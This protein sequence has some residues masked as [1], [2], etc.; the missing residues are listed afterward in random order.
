MKKIYSFVLMAAMLLVGT[1]A[2]AQQVVAKI[3]TQEYYSLQDAVNAVPAGG[4]ATIQLQKSITLDA[5]VVIPQVGTS[6]DDV[7]S[8]ANK[9]VNRAMQHITLDLNGKNISA[10]SNYLGSAFILF[11]GELNITGTGSISRNDASGTWYYST[12]GNFA[13]ATIV[14]C[15]AD[16]NKNDATKD[17]SKQVWSVLNIGENVTIYGK[18]D[19]NKAAGEKEGGFGICIQNFQPSSFPDDLDASVHKANLGYKTYYGTDHPMWW[20]NGSSAGAAFGV[21]VIVAGTIEAY[22][23]GI[24]VLGTVNQSAIKVENANK[25]TSDEYP[26]YAHNYPYIRI[27]KGATVECESDGLESGNGGIYAGGWAVIDIL[28]TVQGQTGVLLKGGDAVVDGGTVKSTSEA[29]SAAADANYGGTVS[30]NAIFIASASNYAGSTNVSIEGGATIDTDV[31]GGAAIVDKVATNTATA[32]TPTVEHVTIVEGNIDGGISI[33]DGTAGNTTIINATIEDGITING[34]AATPADV[35][36]MFV[37]GTTNYDSGVEEPSTLVNLVPG[38]TTITVVPNTAKNVTLNAYG[39]ATYSFENADAGVQKRALHA[40]W[41]AFTGK[42]DNGNFVLTELVEAE[43][44]L[45]VV[46]PESTGVILYK[47]NGEHAEGEM[48]LTDKTASPISNNDLLAAA[49]WT[50][51]VPQ[52]YV[53]VLVG[54]ELYLY[55]GA[56]MKANKAYLKLD[57]AATPYGAPKRIKVVFA[58]TQDIENVEFEAVKAVKFIENGQVLIKRG[59]NIYNVQ[60]QLVK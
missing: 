27:E 58:E 21:K 35:A 38:T 16:G 12:W 14:V 41:K 5:P 60:G 40:G 34:S 32:S 48:T 22:Q 9:V 52:Q 15:G 24:N 47:E 18:G 6:K 2:W 10:K 56:E 37:P 36:E 17:L 39:L 31:A 53:Y 11:K 42:V 26:F 3:G 25:R 28:G 19:N 45:G 51:N 44:G 30:G 7:V 29:S 43:E 54:N 59:E 55:E 23:R 33:T 4:T 8:D 50:Y 13:K 49:T 46:I 1:N 57:A 20:H